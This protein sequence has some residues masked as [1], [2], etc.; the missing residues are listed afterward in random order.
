MRLK[1]RIG[2]SGSH[3][4]TITV[5]DKV[6][7]FHIRL[8]LIVACIITVDKCFDIDITASPDSVLLDSVDP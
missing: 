4:K 3:F 1:I 6:V 5:D 8:Q 7:F 2:E